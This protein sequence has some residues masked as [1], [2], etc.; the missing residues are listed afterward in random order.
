MIGFIGC[1][2]MASAIIR[3]LVKSEACKGEE[4]SVYDIDAEKS[5]ALS[6]ELSLVRAVSTTEIA[7]KC[8]T[9][10]LAVKPNVLADVLYGI[11]DSLKLYD[12]LIISIAA[13]KSTDYIESYLP[14]EPRLVR[15]MPNIN[16]TCG[17]SVTAYCGN[18]RVESERGLID[19]ATAKT[20]C[21]SFGAAFR[22]QEHQFSIFSAM[23]GCSPA[24]V[25]MFIDS[26]ARAGVKY[27]MPRAQAVEIARAAVHG[28]ALMMGDSDKH[29]MELVDAVCSPGGTTVEGVCA[30][31]E[32][33][34][35]TAV[36]KAVEAS[37]NKD[38][39]LR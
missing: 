11:C 27:G 38:K 36:E 6:D 29:P 3:G 9:V 16:A 10:V 37:Y 33:G 17:A 15:I 8:D 24:F 14:Y 4:I 21:S 23:A 22:L 39:A 32:F 20:F 34:F 1:G 13:G 28:S 25:Y 18:G 2:N 30:L 12:P 7:E 31:K 35:E 5:I 19:L 26:I